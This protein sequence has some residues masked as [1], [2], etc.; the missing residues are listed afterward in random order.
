MRI[1]QRGYNLVEI[2]IV[3]VVIL[4]MSSFL[5]VNYFNAEKTR[6]NQE[7]ER[8]IEQIK[9]A[10]VDYAA[11]HH[12]IDHFVGVTIGV[13]VTV[14]QTVPAGRP[15]LPCPDIS[16]DGYEDRV[17]VTIGAVVSYSSTPPNT[18]NPLESTGGC[19]AHRGIVPWR[20]LGTA[21]ADPWGSRY[22]YRVD[23]AFANAVIGFDQHTHAD[24][25]RKTGALVVN[26]A[27]LTVAEVFAP[28][29][30][31]QQVIAAAVAPW[32]TL[33]ENRNPA[34]ICAAGPCAMTAAAAVTLVGGVALTANMAVTVYRPHFADSNGAVAVTL[35]QAGHVIEGIPFVVVSHGA[36][37]YGGVRAGGG[38]YTCVPFPVAE[39]RLS[40]KTNAFWN[41]QV[42]V[43]A[44]GAVQYNCPSVT[45]G[46]GAFENRFVDGINHGTRVDEGLEGYDDL[47]GWMSA[48]EMVFA[49]NRRRAL[50]ARLLPP[51]GLE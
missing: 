6:R 35:N 44:A 24:S 4:M 47:V 39:S 10:V 33:E 12:T 15:Y 3:L 26:S 29:A 32:G 37:R 19:A 49:L 25:S 7:V 27:G 21:A 17:E 38:G 43:A 51:I 16:G 46:P 42:A 14:R 2:A 34:I 11:S 20:T 36:N 1:R 5:A 23:A 40:E 30:N 48:E 45:A 41:P 22:S 50:P 31:R 13:S 28:S 9:E 18:D 8:Q